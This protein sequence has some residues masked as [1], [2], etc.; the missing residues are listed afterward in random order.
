[1][2]PGRDPRVD[3]DLPTMPTSIEAWANALIRLESTVEVPKDNK[4]GYFLPQPALIA[5]SQGV[6]LEKYYGSWLCLRPSL[7]HVYHSTEGNISTLTCQSWR[8]YLS[9]ASSLTEGLATTGTW[10]R[11]RHEAIRTVMSTIYKASDIADSRDL[12]FQFHDELFPSINDLSVAVR[13]EILWEIFEMG[14]FFELHALDRD[15]LAPTQVT[16]TVYIGAVE[17]TRRDLISRIFKH[18]ACTIRVVRNSAYESL[19]RLSAEDVTHRA[20]S[21]EALRQVLLRWPGVPPFVQK[22]SSLT[23]TNI[24]RQDLLDAERVMVEFYVQTFL[25]TAGCPPLVPH[26]CPRV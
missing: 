8:D 18:H 1:M 6:R 10:A 24:C 15:V 21:L 3:P 7:Y 14:F 20:P 19:A 4:W 2:F 5:N 17:V 16:D 9:G 22:V 11:G 23:S 26:V 12:P 25:D 13:K